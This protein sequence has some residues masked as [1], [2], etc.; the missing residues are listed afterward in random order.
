MFDVLVVKLLFS[1]VL[2]PFGGK[3]CDLEMKVCTCFLLAVCGVGSVGFGVL[4]VNND[5]YVC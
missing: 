1:H 5:D 3:N 4:S 2:S